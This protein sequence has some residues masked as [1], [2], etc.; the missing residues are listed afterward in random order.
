MDGTRR[1]G[2]RFD[3]RWQSSES[4][5][6]TIS[7]NGE[8]EESKCQIETLIDLNSPDRGTGPLPATPP[9]TQPETKLGNVYKTGAPHLNTC[10]DLK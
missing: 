10:G 8:S 4:P 5:L 7:V 6:A 2:V 9:Q 3:F 1:R